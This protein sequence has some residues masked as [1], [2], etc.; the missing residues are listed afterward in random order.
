MN[1]GEFNVRWVRGWM[2]GSM[3][4]A[5]RMVVGLRSFLLLRTVVSSSFWWISVRNI[6]V[7][8]RFRRF[9]DFVREM[10]ENECFASSI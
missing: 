6:R 1:S 8:A 5:S 2:V 4:S 7:G 10:D 3:D 9:P